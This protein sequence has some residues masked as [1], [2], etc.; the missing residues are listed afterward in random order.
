[1]CDVCKAEGIDYQFRTNCDY[2]YE[3]KLYKV[4]KGKIARVLLCRLHDIELF[5]K[6]ELRFLR[7]YIRLAHKLADERVPAKP[8]FSLF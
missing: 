4:Y 2:L 3:T 6:G 5:R 7:Q 8:A 1:M